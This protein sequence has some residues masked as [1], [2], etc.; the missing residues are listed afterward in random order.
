MV[1]KDILLDL[2]RHME[3]A[4]AEVWTAVLAAENGPGDTKL[5]GL[6]YHL[7]MVQRAF[8]RTWRGE[9]RDTPYPR[10]IFEPNSIFPDGFE[11]AFGGLAMVAEGKDYRTFRITDL[12]DNAPGAE[13]GLQ[14]N[15]I[16]TA[17]DG[18]PVA[19]LTLTKVIEL[20]ERP[21]TYKLTVRRGEQ[22]LQVT[23]TPRKMV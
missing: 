18:K 23:L 7:H 10:I 11:R 16:I 6:L 19:E 1:N 4:D 8:L 12:L 2:Y 3:W 9:P 17:I 22:T 21:V 14:K 15:D 13:A 20:F 5:R